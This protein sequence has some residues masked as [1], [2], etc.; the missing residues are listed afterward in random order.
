MEPN[1]FTFLSSRYP[2]DVVLKIEREMIMER[3]RLVMGEH[4][5]KFREVVFDINMN[6]WKNPLCYTDP[7]Y[8]QELEDKMLSYQF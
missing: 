1:V 2:I 3:R 5:S 6:S 8:F 7:E 4:K